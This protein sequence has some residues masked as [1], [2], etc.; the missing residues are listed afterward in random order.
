MTLRGPNRSELRRSLALALAIAAS[1]IASCSRSDA[2]K[3]RIGV[4]MKSF[5]DPLCAG[6]RKAMEAEAE[7]KAE[8]SFVD[9]RGR[10]EAQAANFEALASRK[11]KAVVIDPVDEI[12][13]RS[14]VIK[15]KERGIPAVFFGSRPGDDSMRSWD[16]VFFVGARDADAGSMQA[17]ILADYWKS[18]PSADK[19]RDGKMQLVILAGESGLLQTL[20]RSEHVV[21]ALDA[22]GVET[23]KLLEQSAKGSRALAS[24]KMAEALAKFGDRIEAVACNDDQ[25]ALGAIDA[26][27]A[28]GWFKGKKSMPVVGVCDSGSTQTIAEALESGR[29]L[30]TAFLDAAAVGRATLALSLALAT[31][32][33]PSKGSPIQDAKYVWIPYRALTK[34]SAAG[35]AAASR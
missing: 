32:E 9:S 22:A 28:A 18:R 15:A 10:S 13:A 26:C 31:G 6:S 23:D 29:L 19:N 12:S 21:R 27:E 1:L 8:L 7:G 25:M 33:D 34:E 3:P 24:E 4:L 35:A 16:K 17:G 14:I 20:Y 30:G 2:G 5:D 11:A